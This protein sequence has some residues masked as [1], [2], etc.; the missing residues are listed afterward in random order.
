MSS[1]KFACPLCSQHIECDDQYAGR[2]IKC[3]ACGGDI[4]I[5]SFAPAPAPAPRVTVVSTSAAHPKPPAPGPP[6]PPRPQFAGAKQLNA[7]KGN[8]GKRIAVT[9]LVVL[10]LLPVGYFAFTGVSRM[11]SKLN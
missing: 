11:Q 10:I 3:P 5:P 1:H 8:T 4:L 7:S 2:Q 9:A 6:V